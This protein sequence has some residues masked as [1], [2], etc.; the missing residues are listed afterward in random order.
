MKNMNT[1]RPWL[2]QEYPEPLPS[3]PSIDEKV[4]QAKR[5]AQQ[6]EKELAKVKKKYLA[7]RRAQKGPDTVE[8]IGVI[9]RHL[10]A[11]MECTEAKSKL[12]TLLAIQRARKK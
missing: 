9:A 3:H 12:R 8:R 7:L 10:R 5:R 11:R 1:L 2:P 6:A 4:E